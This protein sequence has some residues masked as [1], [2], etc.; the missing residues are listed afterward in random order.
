MAFQ[1]PVTLT[2]TGLVSPYTSVSKTNTID[3]EVVT[4]LQV[5]VPSGTTDYAIN[6]NI[7]NISKVFSKLREPFR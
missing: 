5:V 2:Q 3:Q 7:L 4:Q 1:V 6:L